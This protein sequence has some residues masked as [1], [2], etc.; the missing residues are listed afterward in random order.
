[1]LLPIALSALPAGCRGP[2]IPA[3][4]PDL[5]EGRLAAAWAAYERDLELTRA[6]V[7]VDPTNTSF[8]RDLA[9][10]WHWQGDLAL[11]EGDL[12]AARAAYGRDR[13]LTAAL[14]AADSTNAGWQRDLAKAEGMLALL[15]LLFR[16]RNVFKIHHAAALAILA[17]L[18]QDG[19]AR[20]SVEH[21]QLRVSLEA[22]GRRAERLLG[23]RRPQLSN[24]WRREGRVGSG[25]RRARPYP[26]EEMQ[27][28][29]PAREHGRSRSAGRSFPLGAGSTR[30]GHLDDEERRIAELEAGSLAGDLGIAADGRP[31]SQPDPV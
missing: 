18:E 2:A 10:S 17:R 31:E 29:P 26:L 11:A 5:A 12:A 23:R 16:S 22:L 27:T 20:G 9:V 7:A 24:R 15:A 3:T 21:V 8:R 25:R 19:R 13:E 14:A 1:M 28:V 6:L 30:A 4:L